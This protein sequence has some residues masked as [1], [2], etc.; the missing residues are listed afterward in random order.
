MGRCASALES[1]SHA[2]LNFAGT[3]EI[4]GVDVEGFAEFGDG[5]GKACAGEAGE[6]IECGQIAGG[7]AAFDG[8]AG[9]FEQGDVLVVEKVEA[10]GEEFEFAVFAEGESLAES[11]VG[12]P[13]GGIAIGVAAD[14]E[15]EAVGEAIEAVVA[16]GAVDA[17]ADAFN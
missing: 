4:C 17:G 6:E 1:G 16:A 9:G 11:G 12:G 10:F 13:G 8:V 2:E 15:G 5:A 3:V 14:V 7:G